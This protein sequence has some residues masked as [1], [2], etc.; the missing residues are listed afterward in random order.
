M[1]LALLSF[2]GAAEDRFQ[3][4]FAGLSAAA[5]TLQDTGN[6]MQHFQHCLM[7]LQYRKLYQ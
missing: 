2:E 1:R 7:E 5:S 3:Q 6:C 4:G